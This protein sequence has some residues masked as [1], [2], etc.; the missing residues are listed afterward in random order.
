L[1]DTGKTRE[2]TV[3][4][5]ISSK[6]R[7]KDRGKTMDS[8]SSRIVAITVLLAAFVG[9]TQQQSPQKLQQK[10][11]QATEEVKSDAQ[12]VAAG[13]REGWNHD[14]PLD[15][16]TATK[17]QLISLPGVTSPEAD[18]VIAGRPYS[19]PNELV[20]RHIMSR[21]EFDKISGQVVAKK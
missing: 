4:P 10:T 2:P 13:V 19:D 12:A 21:A 16:N 11:A 15:V 1:G 14:R 6:M 7:K 20:T 17:D 18:R 8:I 5:E 9:C 3:S